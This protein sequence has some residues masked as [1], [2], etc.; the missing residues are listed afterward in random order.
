MWDSWQ[1]LICVN[2]IDFNLSG[3]CFK[4]ISDY[5]LSELVFGWVIHY[6]VREFEADVVKPQD[7]FSCLIVL[8]FF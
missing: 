2:E 1:K 3:M 7:V 5:I 8:V 4:Y 6:Q